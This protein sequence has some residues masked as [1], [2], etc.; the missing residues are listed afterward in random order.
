MVD[1]QRSGTG[2]RMRVVTCHFL[3]VLT[4]GLVFAGVT[5]AAAVDTPKQ[6]L[7]TYVDRLFAALDDPALKDPARAGD[8]HRTIRKLAE[9]A[10]DFRESARR[11]LG[12][13]W[14]ARTEAER[15]RF[16]GL[17]ADLIDQAYLARLNRDGERLELDSETIAGTEAIVKGRAV[18]KEGG[19]TPVTFALHR[20]AANAWRVYDVQFEGMSLVGNYRAQFN[21]IIR[22]SSFEELLAR[23][24]AK[25]RAE[26][27][28]STPA[29]TPKTTAP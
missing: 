12:S 4:L 19:V 17:F 18:Q 9:E 27:Q 8:R 6:A 14:E 13:H 5:P 15:T 1:D 26:G 3:A 10:L 21:K 25:T 2:G 29:E 20:D 11:A 16:T 7:R 24:E 23:L 28:A 22:T